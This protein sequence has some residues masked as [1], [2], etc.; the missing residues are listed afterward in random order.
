MARPKKVGLDY[1]PLDTTFDDETELFLD[2]FGAKGMM[3]LIRFWQ[4]AYKSENGVLSFKTE[5]HRKSFLKKLQLSDDEFL[6]I[7]KAAV[8]MGILD[9]GMWELGQLTSSGIKKRLLEVEKQRNKWR[10]DSEEREENNTKRDYPSGYLMLTDELSNVNYEEKCIK[11]NKA[12]IKQKENKQNKTDFMH[13]SDAA[14]LF[15]KS[16]ALLVSAG[17]DSNVSAI[18]SKQFDFER[19]KQQI[20]WFP[21][22]KVAT[23]PLGFLRKAIE[24]N[25]EE[26]NSAKMG[27]KKRP[28]R[29]IYK[30]HREEITEAGIKILNELNNTLNKKR[31]ERNGDN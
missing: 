31:G 4:Q 1:F 2:N 19:I 18:I 14:A 3:F 20:D 15:R 22:R 26:P 8:A 11:Q 7:G 23:N 27:I 17:F 13:K 9:A 28:E 21:K 10:K 30:P 16:F 24:E 12:N 6:E 5:L 25:W 29:E